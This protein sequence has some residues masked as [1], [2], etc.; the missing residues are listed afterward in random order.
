SS[1]DFY[2]FIP[3]TPRCFH[4]NLVPFEG[5]ITAESRALHDTLNIV[6]LVGSI[7]NDFCGT[8]MTI[9]ADSAL[10]RI[11]E[12]TDAITTTAHSH[13]RCFILEVM[14]RHCGY[15]AIVAALASE[16]DWVFVPE[17]P[18]SDDWQERL[19]R[20][21]ISVSVE[22]DRYGILIHSYL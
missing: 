4:L 7:D 9:G 14:G 16:A 22:K 1:Y 6:G 10:H 3:F 2:L 8:D 17:S 15:L 19:Y 21:L 5:V 13:Q 12:A 18:P 11:I 20:R